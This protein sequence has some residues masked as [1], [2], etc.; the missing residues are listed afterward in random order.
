MKPDPT[1]LLYGTIDCH[2]C[3][4]AQAMVYQALGISL[5]I[6][7]I[8]DEPALLARYS[9]RIPV[10][11]HTATGSELDWPFGIAEVQQL[12]YSLSPPSIP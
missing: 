9:L 2:L 6:T 4:Q 1:L 7:E 12:Y 8:V 10:L 5:D 3:E 11:Q